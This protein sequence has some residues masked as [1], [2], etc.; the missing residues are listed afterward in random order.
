MADG[1]R[2]GVPSNRGPALK[3]G[4]SRVIEG[5]VVSAAGVD[6]TGV[7]LDTTP[8]LPAG[9][10][11]TSIT[12]VVLTTTPSLPAGALATSLTGVVLTTTPTLPAGSLTTAV[13]GVVLTVTPTLP[14]GSLTTNVTGVVLT[15]TPSLPAGGVQVNQVF[16]V[17]LETTPTL[18]AGEATAVTVIT[19]VTLETTPTLP[20]GALATS[21]TGVTLTTAPSQ[22]A[23]TL[24]TSITGVTLTATPTLP[25]GELTEG[26]PA[27]P[28]IP[29]LPLRAKVSPAPRL[30]SP[31]SRITFGLPA[32]NDQTVTGVTLTTTPELPAG[33]FEVG[34][35]FISANRGAG[36]EPPKP[37]FVVSRIVTVP[38]PLAQTV[39]GVTLTTTPTLPAGSIA[40]EAETVTG[41]VLVTTSTLPAGTLRINSNLQGFVLLT[42]PEMPE[43]S[44]TGGVAPPLIDPD[45]MARFN[46]PTGTVVVTKPV[47][48]SGLRFRRR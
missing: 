44:V 46:L 9:A 28:P 21:L 14:A 13:T 38:I 42:T 15:T 32:T 2:W 25:A 16:G 5:F 7:T 1:V 3:P 4:G 22:P 36:S 40:F 33:H 24:S 26:A 8:T 43:G 18:P 23:G 27:A 48:R 19:G 20:A 41:V 37:K 29:L 45:T 10:L 11:A 30:K 35:I 6:V 47:L 31:V 39:T 12:G 34:V 17:T